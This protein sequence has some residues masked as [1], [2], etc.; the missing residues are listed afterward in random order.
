V[1]KFDWRSKTFWLGILGGVKLITDSFG[2]NLISN[3]Q[4]DDIA[5]GV[6]AILAVVAMIMPHRKEE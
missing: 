6:A 4:V 5:T 3:E 1:G 2:F